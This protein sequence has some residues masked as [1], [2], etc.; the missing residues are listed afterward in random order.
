MCE[1]LHLE[2][3]HSAE[4]GGGGRGRV[5]SEERRGRQEQDHGACGRLVGMSNYSPRPVDSWGEFH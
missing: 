3:R 2:S 5:R 4:R 1:L